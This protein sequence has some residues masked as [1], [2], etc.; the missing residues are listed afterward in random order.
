M[1]KSPPTV[2]L[3]CQLVTYANTPYCIELGYVFTERARNWRATVVIKNLNGWCCSDV[4]EYSVVVINALRR[5]QVEL[6]HY[7][8]GT[9]R[10][11]FAR[12]SKTTAIC[13]VSV[14]RL[15]F[16]RCE[17]NRIVIMPLYKED[18]INFNTF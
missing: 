13:V 7:P 12:N 18:N 1:L 15:N 14:A 16:Y 6:A 3:R 9:A 17:T 10:I 8:E 5:A 2:L 11:I 4:C